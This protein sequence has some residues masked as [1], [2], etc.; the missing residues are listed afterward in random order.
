MTS[1]LILK[2]SY[3]FVLAV[4]LS[5]MI[6]GCV[7]ASQT[8]EDGT[9]GSLPETAATGTTVQNLPEAAASENAGSGP[10]EG[11]KALDN[12]SGK[13]VLMKSII[14]PSAQFKPQSG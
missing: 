8:G 10:Q 3:C 12:P 1:G 2:K 9:G 11:G 7:E 4:M 6:T 14:Y 13:K 5:L